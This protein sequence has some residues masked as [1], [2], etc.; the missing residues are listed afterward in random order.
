V[1]GDVGR[2]AL[3]FADFGRVGRKIFKEIEK[4]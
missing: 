1:A 4:H 2:R 3:A